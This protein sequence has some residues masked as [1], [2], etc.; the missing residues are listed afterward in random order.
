MGQQVTIPLL[1]YRSERH[2]TTFGHVLVCSFLCYSP[3]FS[4][5]I[6][7][8]FLLTHICYYRNKQLR[9]HLVSEANDSTLPSDFEITTDTEL[10][11]LKQ[12]ILVS[13]HAI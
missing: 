3:F 7:H 13:E 8:T 11:R 10:G 2:V 4:D 6:T 5:N 9:A 12:D 1:Y